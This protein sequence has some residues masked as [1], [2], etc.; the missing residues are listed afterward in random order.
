LDEPAEEAGVPCDGEDEEDWVGLA[1]GK[2]EGEI[3]EEPAS[4]E[5][6]KMSFCAPSW[7]LY[8]SW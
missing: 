4:V 5:F 7:K 2:E 8:K 6:S 1:V 3:L